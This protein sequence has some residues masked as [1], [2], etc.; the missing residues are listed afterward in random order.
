[1]EPRSTFPQTFFSVGSFFCALKKLSISKVGY[2]SSGLISPFSATLKG[3]YL[4]LLVPFGLNGFYVSLKYHENCFFD[5]VFVCLSLRIHL[6]I[7][8][9]LL[10]LMFR[11]SH[12]VTFYSSI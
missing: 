9:Y 3:M 1:M 8:L 5:V 7:V 6:K 10:N 11:V 4:L 2:S 12:V